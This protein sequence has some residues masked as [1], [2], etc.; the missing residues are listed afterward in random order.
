V[1]MVAA[2][3]DVDEEDRVCAAGI[4]VGACSA[5]ARRLPALEA[6]L[7]GLPRAQI[8]G[9]ARRLLGSDRAAMLSPLSPIDDVRGSAGYR[10]DAVA[11]L[12]GRLLTEL[13]E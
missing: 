10:L 5:A 1:A 9:Q 7:A 3:I 4:A 6:A 8:G 2:I 13:A 12:L 11:T